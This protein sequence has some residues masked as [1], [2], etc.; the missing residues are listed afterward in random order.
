MATYEDDKASYDKVVA[1]MKEVPPLV[2]PKECQKLISQMAECGRGE[3]FLVLGGDCAEK[4]ASCTEAYISEQC[5]VLWKMS[6]IIQLVT[7]KPTLT[8][9]RMA[10]QYGK[11]RSSP[12]E[13]VEGWGK[14]Y[15]YKGEN[16]NG[17]EPADRQWDPKRLLDG[18]WHS[19]ATLNYIRALKS[20]PEE[21]EAI[22]KTLD[23]EALKTS[24]DFGAEAEV[25]DASIKTQ[26]STLA[27]GC[28]MFTAHEGMQLD[29][30]E[31]LTRKAKDGQYY[32]LSTN[33]L[34]IGD[35]TRQ[36]THGHIEYFKGIGNPVGCKTG[37]TMKPDEI[38]ELVQILNPN[39]IEGKLMIITRYGAGKVKSI[40]PGH[41]K[42]VQ[43][44]GVPVVW[45][46]DG[47]HGNTKSAKGGYKTRDINAVVA[48]CLESLEVHRECGSILGGI[49][50][51][52]TGQRGVTECIGGC[53]GLGEDDLPRQYET[54]CDPRLNYS[55]GLEA[56]LRVAKALK[57]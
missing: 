34:W 7:G 15:S 43:A 30:E 35:R 24:P 55:Q 41:I 16:I 51:E 36:L 3:R 13:N 18:V 38:A 57:C 10:G 40:L 44:T 52:V 49:H 11:P 42:A 12:M 33:M 48:E 47:V 21:I 54:Y 20:D 8:I 4:F 2:T 17:Y 29:L 26:A 39:K 50:L 45:Q 1:K 27:K 53:C 25:L 19:H 5:G 9:G 14:I 31:C 46:V 23:V 22:F 6:A 56:A 28:E 32:N 37:P